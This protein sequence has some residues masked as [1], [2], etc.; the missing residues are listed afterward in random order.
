MPLTSPASI[1]SFDPLSSDSTQQ[2]RLG[3]KA[4][5]VDGRNFR[6]AKA[7]TSALVAGTLQTGP[8]IVA[9]HHNLA[10]AA[11]SIGAFQVTVTLGATLASI[12][13]YAEGYLAVVDGTGEG[14]I[15]LIKSH[16]A[17]ASSATVV[18]DLHEP[19]KVALV[20]SSTS[21]V[22][23]YP[24]PYNATVIAAT[25]PVSANTGW[26]PF[27]VPASDFY[28]SHTHGLISALIDGT[29][30]IGAAVSG[31]NAVAGAVESGVIGQGVVGQMAQTGVD[32]E[33]RLVFA[34]ID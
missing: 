21:E 27:A 3:T 10:V 1:F 19:I 26:A 28:W 29:P 9:N 20:A 32:T 15:Y 14:H 2:H 13:Q 34:T 31:S 24:N 4:E 23:L 6:Y 7:G 30:A 22:T 33:E 5:T 16:P 12:N 17:A 8:A 18:V 25:T 11:A